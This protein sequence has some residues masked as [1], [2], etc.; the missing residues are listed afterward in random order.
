MD[1]SKAEIEY[2]TGVYSYLLD[3]PSTVYS[4]CRYR[5]HLW[6]VWIADH[7]VNLGLSDEWISGELFS[8]CSFRP[9]TAGGISK[10]FRDR[11]L[12]FEI[13]PAVRVTHEHV[14]NNSRS[15]FSAIETAITVGPP[16]PRVHA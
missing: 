11:E 5:P 6:P 10:G 7:T 13:S 9:L 3:L 12:P 14:E 15:P 2:A 4:C 1:L 8:T 16:S